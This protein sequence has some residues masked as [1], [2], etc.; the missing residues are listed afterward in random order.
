MG[1][2]NQSMSVRASQAY[3]RGLKP[4]SKW[5]K[6][7]II[8]GVAD[9]G[10]WDAETLRK[11]PKA[12]LADFFLAYAEWHHTGKMFN[13]TCFFEVDPDAAG[14]VD[15]DGLDRLMAAHR[16]A[17]R[18]KNNEKPQVVKARIRFEEWSGSRNY[19]RFVEHESYALVVDGWAWTEDGRKKLDSAHMLRVER[20]G[21][22]PR[23][24]A[25][26]FARI[27]GLMPKKYQ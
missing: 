23:G 17:V 21:R 11:Y 14:A 22:A 18:A 12:V 27:R 13:E 26:T 8:E 15:V 10:A 5:S 16:E 25:E 4:L 2:I 19:G 9:Y 7:D 20:L 3:G 1:Y 6:A 24:T